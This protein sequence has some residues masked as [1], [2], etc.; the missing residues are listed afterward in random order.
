MKINNDSS[1]TGVSQASNRRSKRRASRSAGNKE[2]IVGN[3]ACPKCRE[4]G[5]DSSGNHMIIFEGGTGWCSRCTVKFSEEE[6]KQAKDPQNSATNSR[7]VR[8]NQNNGGSG[9]NDNYPKKKTLEDMDHLGLLG[10]PKRFIKPTTDKHFGIR[11]EI[12]TN[13]RKPKARYY[14]YTA[15]E[16]VVGYKTRL[17]PKDWG[18][19]IGTI[20]G[21]DLCGWEQCQGKRRTLIITE[22]EED[23]AAGYQLWKALNQ[24]SDDRR[25]KRAVPHIVSLPDGSKGVVKILM[26]HLNELQ[27]YDKII[28]MGD[29]IKIDEEGAKALELAVQVLGV[30]KLYVP[31]YPEGGYK[32]LCD[33]NMAFKGSDEAVDL[34][35]EMFFQN[36]VYSPMDVVHGKDMH[37]SEF[38]KEVVQGYSLP[39][40]SIDAALQGLR[41]YEHT[42]IFSGSGMGKSTLC[43]AIGHWMA[44]E[45]DWLVGNI[46]LEEQHTKTRQGYM[47]YDNEVALN[48]YR[49]DF[50]IISDE[51]KDITQERVM[52]KMMYLTHH[53]SINT[54]VLMNKVR[55]LANMGCKLII[56]DHITMATNNDD[57]PTKAIDD[58]MEEIYNFCDVNPVHILSVVHLTKGSDKRDFTRGAEITPNNLKGSS[59]LMQMV[60]NALAVEGDNQ[61]D[62][63]PDTR[64]VRSLK[65]RESGFVG[66]MDGA[67][68]YSKETGRFKYDQDLSRTS[69]DPVY[70]EKGSRKPNM[71]SKSKFDNKAV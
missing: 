43:R 4:K 56:F 18:Q 2:S 5:G 48:N 22:G 19:A 31:D 30:K 24:R 16:D 34:F 65:C 70:E 54:D 27:K 3:T 8:R 58:L 26:K 41:L 20:K 49:K 69:I 36:E 39:F 67:Y 11:T 32:D 50:S 40:P 28:W 57:N 53:G 23:M 46:F 55:Y 66:I 71:G 7:R 15:M 68:H 35:A 29:N 64:W 9:W 44:T 37:W 12:D 63:Y 61:H 47:A 62:E 52:D 42:L 51:A 14:P 1:T 10:N 17:L 25:I 59:G 6:V 38:E 21:V 60:W 45:H 33:I 13:T